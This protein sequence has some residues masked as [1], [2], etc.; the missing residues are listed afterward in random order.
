M[1]NDTLKTGTTLQRG[2]YRITKV[3]G[4]TTFDITYLAEHV[5]L[6]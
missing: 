5:F 1:T 4:Q 6:K 3:L 2:K